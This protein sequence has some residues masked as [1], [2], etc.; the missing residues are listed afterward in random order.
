MD[1][2]I[3]RFSVIMPL[4]N[5]VAYVEKAIRSVLGQTYP[6]YE[7]I[8]VNDGSTDLLLLLKNY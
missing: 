7:L 5:K 6:H 8:V 2:E 4:Y 3:I 1:Q